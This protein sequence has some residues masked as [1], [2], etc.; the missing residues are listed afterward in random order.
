M[1]REREAVPRVADRPGRVDRLG[2]PDRAGRGEQAREQEQGQTAASGD[3]GLRAE[4]P[5]A[6]RAGYGNGP[7]TT[8]VARSGWRCARAASFT[9]GTVTA[10]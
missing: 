5:G 7:A 2:G 6:D 8:T 4:A 1:D 9:C 3:D 10:R